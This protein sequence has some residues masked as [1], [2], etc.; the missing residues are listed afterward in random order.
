MAQ[1]QLV[2]NKTNELLVALE[3]EYARLIDRA[4]R[5]SDEQGR[6]DLGYKIRLSLVKSLQRLD[7]ITPEIELSPRDVCSFTEEPD[8][9][10]LNQRGIDRLLSDCGFEP[11]PGDPEHY[12][13]ISIRPRA[14][15]SQSAEW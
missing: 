3:G 1:L 9:S 8:D 7:L 12:R 10:L 13:P 2:P 6:K 4:L 15:A 5:E 11:L 14:A